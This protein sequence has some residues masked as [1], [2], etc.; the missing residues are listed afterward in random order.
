[1]NTY[2]KSGEREGKF[3]KIFY[4]CMVHAVTVEVP[5]RL[6]LWTINAISPAVISTHIIMIGG[7]AYSVSVA[8]FTTWLT[9]VASTS[10]YS[11]AGVLA[12]NLRNPI[13]ASG[14]GAI[15]IMVSG[16]LP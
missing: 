13:S 16:G 7:L 11:C 14:I 4:K 8:V 9:L 3:C 6:T 1:M 5:G 10:L 15:A 12:L 2:V